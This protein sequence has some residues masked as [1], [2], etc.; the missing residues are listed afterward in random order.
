MPLVTSKYNPK[1]IFKNGHFATIYSAKLRKPPKLTQKRERLMLPDGD[2]LD[3]DFSFSEGPSEKIAILLHGLEGNAQRTYMVGQA[4]ILNKKGWDACAVNLRGCSGEPNW[5]FESYTAG[6]T[7]DLHWVVEYVL[8]KNQY[9][10]IALVG[11][12]LGGN[13]LLKYLGEGRETPK[14]I[15][16]GIAISTPVDLK[17][18]LWKLAQWENWLYRSVFLKDLRKKVSHK[19]HQFPE[20]ISEK[21]L[22]KITSLKAFDDWYTAPANGFEDAFDYYQK[23]SSLQ[24]LPEIPVPVLILNAQ[25]DSFLPSECYPYSLAEKSKI[26]YLETPKYG[27]HVGFHLTEKV[28]YSEKRTLEF[29]TTK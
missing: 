5:K 17:G 19:I 1:G 26:L 7:E 9:K 21:E 18:T 6:K 27:G 20:Q 11:F 29:L 14:E 22:H 15:K 10:E 4:S 8:G 25:N 12:S 24:F 3:L 16:K 2:F 13:L 23:N 28:Y